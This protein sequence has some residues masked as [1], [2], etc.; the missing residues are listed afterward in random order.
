[1]RPIL[2]VHGGAGS[3]R[4]SLDEEKL[5]G[6]KNAARKGFETLLRKGAVDAVEV[7]VKIMEDNPI[8][9]AGF[10]SVLNQGGYVEMDAAIMDGGSLK[11][12]AV[13]CVR[14]VKNPIKLARIILEESDYVL[15]AGAEA[16]KLAAQKGLELHSPITHERVN[17]WATVRLEKPLSYK[18]PRYSSDRC[19]T[20][21][22]VALDSEGRLAA[23]VST[24]GLFLKPPGR[25]G[26]SAIIG[27]GIYAENGVGAIV[28]TGIGEAAIRLGAARYILTLI[29]AGI[30]P[31]KALD[32]LFKKLSGLKPSMS[33]GAIMINGEGTPFAGHTTSKMSVAYMTENM[34]DPKAFLRLP[35]P[36]TILT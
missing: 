24:G 8:F 26:D 4:D 21:G 3:W 33:L 7:A 34:D 18:F 28:F 29:E 27:A 5:N 19:D 17:Q 1:M 35:T 10:G 23:A 25:I 14:F 15:L 30:P 12:G 6:V 32:R 13:A 9:N 36:S 11:A 31:Q 16:E 20:V 22:C 2:I